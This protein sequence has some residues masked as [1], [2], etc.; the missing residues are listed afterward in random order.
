MDLAHLFY[1]E[2]SL[3]VFLLATVL[4]GGG[5]A[6]LA[7]RAVAAT[8]RPVWQVVAYAL[9]LGGAVRFIHF[10]L[11]G[12]TLLSAHYYAVD[13]AVCL[14]L[15][16]LGFRLRRVAQMTRRY[17]WINARA[18]LLRWKAREGGPQLDLGGDGRAG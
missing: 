15:A 11:F 10:A 1:E 6:F 7:G 14:G 12:G 18:G 17:P 8:W 16:A 3:G 2:D 5:A 9:V 13:A 4:L